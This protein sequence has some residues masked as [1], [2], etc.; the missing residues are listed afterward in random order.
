MKQVLPKSKPQASQL[1]KSRRKLRV[2]THMEN[3]P[4]LTSIYLNVM[5]IAK[6][7]PLLETEKTGKVGHYCMLLKT[8]CQWLSAQM[9]ALVEKAFDSH[10]TFAISNRQGSGGWMVLKTHPFLS[11]ALFTQLFLPV[12]T[13][14]HQEATRLHSSLG[15]LLKRNSHALGREGWI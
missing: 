2:F 11:H 7:L 3:L 5:Q 6:W 15:K 12:L 13:G 4:K 8:N 9:L 1:Q 10:N 14:A